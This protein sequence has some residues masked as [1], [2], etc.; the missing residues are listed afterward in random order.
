MKIIYEDEDY[1]LRPAH[2]LW[3]FIYALI[4]KNPQPMNFTLQE[5]KVGSSSRLTN[6]EQDALGNVADLMTAFWM[7]PEMQGAAG[8]SEELWRNTILRECIVAVIAARNGTVS[9]H[10]RIADG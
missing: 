7:V 2:P 6:Q 5:K 10:C 8:S 3:G 1:S 4:K 9:R